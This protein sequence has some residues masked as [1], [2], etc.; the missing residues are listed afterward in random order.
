[1]N[2]IENIPSSFFP[3]FNEKSVFE[4]IGKQ[5]EVDEK[6]RITKKG[7]K[8]LTDYLQ[9]Y[10]NK[11]FESSRF[12]FID[13]NGKIVAHSAATSHLPNTTILIADE[14]SLKLNKN[15]ALQN[16]CKILIA[17]NHPSGNVVASPEDKKETEKIEKILGSAFYGHIILDHGSF[18]C[19]IRGLNQNKWFNFRDG[20]VLPEEYGLNLSNK[21]TVYLPNKDYKKIISIFSEIDDKEKW[22]T[23]NWIGGL[24]TNLENRVVQLQFFHYSEFEK[25][26]LLESKIKTIAKLTGATQINLT[27]PKEQYKMLLNIQNFCNQSRII[28]S[29]CMET[30]SGFESRLISSNPI[31]NEKDIKLESYEDSRGIKP[32]LTGNISYFREEDEEDDLIQKEIK[33]S[34]PSSKSWNKNFPSVFSSILYKELKNSSELEEL[35]IKAKSGD[36]TAA[37]LLVEKIL[38]KKIIKELKDKYSDAIVCP[39]LAIEAAGKN[40][41]PYAYA[42]FLEKLGFQIEKNIFQVVKAHHTGA[43]LTDRF[44][45]RARFEGSV[46]NGKNYILIDD[47]I[48]SGGTLRDLK[49]FIESKGGNVVAFSTLTTLNKETKISPSIENIKTLNKYGEKID[50]LLKEFGIT[51][52]KE[53][54]TNGEVSILLKLLSNKRRIEQFKSRKQENLERACKV[55]RDEYA[56]K[57]KIEEK[58]RP[59]LNRY[60]KLFNQLPP[61]D[62]ISLQNYSEKIINA[63]KSENKDILNIIT[64]F[65]SNPQYSKKN[66]SLTQE[67]YFSAIKQEIVF[68]AINVIS[69]PHITNIKISQIKE[70]KSMEN[71]QPTVFNHTIVREEDLFSHEKKL[72]DE[73]YASLDWRPG[74]YGEIETTN[75]FFDFINHEDERLKFLEACKEVDLQDSYGNIQAVEQY[76]CHKFGMKTRFDEDWNPDFYQKNKEFYNQI[77]FI[78]QGIINK[79]SREE[80]II[81][82]IFSNF[83]ENSISGLENYIKKELLHQDISLE[84]NPEISE[85]EEKSIL[86]EEKNNLI[87]EKFN[88]NSHY[89]QISEFLSSDPVA[90][91]KTENLLVEYPALS[92]QNLITAFILYNQNLDVSV[93]NEEQKPIS[94]YIKL[95]GDSELDAYHTNILF[96]ANDTSSRLLTDGEVYLKNLKNDPPE[97]KITTVKDLNNYIISDPERFAFMEGWS[98]IG[99]SSPAKEKSA[100][101]EDAEIVSIENPEKQPEVDTEKLEVKIDSLRKEYSFKN[102]FEVDTFEN[103]SKLDTPEKKIQIQSYINYLNLMSHVENENDVFG[104]FS[105]TEEEYINNELLKSKIILS[106]PIIAGNLLEKSLMT[107]IVN[108]PD[109]SFYFI[110]KTNNILPALSVSFNK[111]TN[112]IF[113]VENANK[114]QW[115]SLQ[116]NSEKNK[117]VENLEKHIED[118]VVNIK[119]YSAENEL[120]IAER[121]GVLDQEIDFCKKLVEKYE[122]TQDL[123]NFIDSVNNYK[124][125]TIENLSIANTEEIKSKETDD[126]NIDKSE[127]SQI[128]ISEEADFEMAEPEPEEFENTNFDYD[129]SMDYEFSD[130]FDAP[131][132]VE[133]EEVP[134]EFQEMPVKKFFTLEEIQRTAGET[135]IDEFFKKAIEECS[136]LE[137]YTKFYEENYKDFEPA[138]ITAGENNTLVLIDKNN[139][140][141]Q[142]AE[143]NAIG[144]TSMFFGAAV[145]RKNVNKVIPS[146]NELKDAIDAFK[147]YDETGTEFNLKN[148]LQNNCFYEKYKK[149]TDLTLQNDLDYQKTVEQYKQMGIPS[150][151][152][153]S[154]SYNESVLWNDFIKPDESGNVYSYGK[155]LPKFGMGKTV[156]NRDGSE[157]IE[158]LNIFEGWQ[159]GGTVREESR[160]PNGELKRDSDGKPIYEDVQKVLCDGG[161]TVLISKNENGKEITRKMDKTFFDSLIKRRMEMN[162]SLSNLK[163]LAEQGKEGLQSKEAVNEKK[164]EIIDKFNAEIGLNEYRLNTAENFHH[165]FVKMASKSARNV[166]EVIEIAN[167]LYKEMTSKEK[168]AFM[169]MKKSYESKYGENFEN[170]LV[171]IYTNATPPLVYVNKDEQTKETTVFAREALVFERDLFDDGKDTSSILSHTQ[172]TQNVMKASVEIDPETLAI[173]SSSGEKIPESKNV[174]LGDSF[175]LSI[176]TKSILPPFNKFRLPEQNYVVFGYSPDAR[177]IELRSRDGKTSYCLPADK[178]LKVLEKQKEMEHK[179]TKTKKK[180][181]NSLEI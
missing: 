8:D 102:L 158:D 181:V 130:N 31:F 84:E 92:P 179:V 148:Y 116:E 146:P 10:S 109:C 169:D 69:I 151:T 164:Q 112:L 157:E 173:K 14:Q 45:N 64:Q 98:G 87:F 41:L 13:N 156:H 138:F 58:T 117:I 119:E 42:F 167:H 44:M 68:K 4:I 60:I 107:A 121:L 16:H 65:N 43:S 136:T 56:K 52:N 17:H 141:I 15:Y 23:R 128:N 7:L 79:K 93:S 125:K 66:L 83:G 123:T 100:D 27:V 120:A 134:L 168:T 137:E 63:I 46:Q 166:N 53:G 75:E 127:T 126:S 165:N 38:D 113:I 39:V 159:L 153:E 24:F 129:E 90:Y 9:I 59:I 81:G 29:L 67:K 103:L 180:V 36:T 115:K 142:K 97:I 140:P 133:K 88:E 118:N 37:Y 135:P 99:P 55:I 176:I 5:V 152:K 172:A 2:N 82:K 47:H 30:S 33:E 131:K 147:E 70:T 71:K 108:V 80:G 110:N 143:D 104:I 72:K 106:E 77:N 111:P 12:L 73:Y 28:F 162:V 177:T 54:L 57:I 155:A 101:I 18:G 26:L 19:Y 48:D 34:M 61:N 154:P 78:A 74:T 150:S 171:R 49:D 11:N 32:E 21:D 94:V 144:R 132:P 51:N 22:N 6:Q 139:N 50:D 89:N 163:Q 124:S 85:P 91:S 174:K 160:Y 170:Y 3:F 62:Q 1:M 145:S 40:K 114:E 175:D 76:L 96:I 161:S 122:N 178:V 95:T 86:S 20:K 105:N 25:P 35:R 149:F